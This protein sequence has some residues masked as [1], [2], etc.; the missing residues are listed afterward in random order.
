[1]KKYIL[2]LTLALLL[3]ITAAIAA[4]QTDRLGRLTRALEEA[5]LQA[6]HQSAE[7]MQALTLDLEK[8]MVSGQASQQ[9]ALLHRISLTAGDV[10]QC[11]ASL[12]LSHE[13]M[14]GTLTFVGELRDDAAAMLPALT[15]RPLT[16]AQLEHLS[17]CLA[18]CAQLSSQ[19][20]LARQ[21]MEEGGMTLT[22]TGSVFSADA[23][24]SQRPL[25]QLGSAEEGVI[26]PPADVR[27]PS[28]PRGLPEGDVTREEARQLARDLVGAEAV[29]A[30]S[31]APDASGVLPAYGV[32]VQTADVL[33]NLEITRQGGKLLWMM[34]ETA[35]FPITQSPA[36]CEDAALGFLTAQGFGP[37]EAVWRQLYDGLCVISFAPVQEGVLLYPDL[38][39]VQVRMDTLQV[40]GL[41][42]RSYWTNHVRRD[43]PDPALS[44]EDASALLSEQAEAQSHR[45]CLIPEGDGET[46]CWQFTVT[47]GGE[48]Y[49]IYLDAQEGREVAIRKLIPLENGATAA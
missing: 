1:M 33:L 14:A 27:L 30:V 28:S 20:S 16:P 48:T 44:A 21:T 9:A 5:G 3:L 6:L 13:A 29:L 31:D 23:S 40:V 42:A 4:M 35:S 38:L 45:L 46:L 24:A 8:L 15:S 7:E 49:L 32:T 43:M 37:A 19:L 12:P 26:Y 2:P 36:A 11:L 41:E 34:P 17:A 47:R 39:T 25:E 10:Q 22:Q 18:S